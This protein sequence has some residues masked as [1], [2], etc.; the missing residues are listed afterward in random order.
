MSTNPL[1]NHVSGSGSVNAL[2]VKDPMRLKIHMDRVYEMMAKVGH[3][4]G[5]YK[6]LTS[7]IFISITMK[8]VT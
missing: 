5:S 6:G 4:K 7:M 2:K 8:K 1:P 3:K